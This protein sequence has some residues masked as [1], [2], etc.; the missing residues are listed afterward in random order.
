M[1]TGCRL[2]NPNRRKAVKIHIFRRGSDYTRHPTFDNEF[3]TGEE[4]YNYYN[5]FIWKERYADCVSFE[6]ALSMLAK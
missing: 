6:S 5:K 2:S 4:N 3:M 1:T